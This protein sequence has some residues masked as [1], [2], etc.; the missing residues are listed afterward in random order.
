MFAWL[1]LHVIIGAFYRPIRQGR[2]VAYLTLVSFIFLV[3]ALVEMFV[4]TK[5]GGAAEKNAG[6]VESKQELQIEN[7]KLQI[8][9]LGVPDGDRSSIFN[10]QFAICNLQF[11]RSAL[12]G[13]RPLMNV[14]VVGCSHHGTSIVIRERLAFGRQQAEEAL[15][16]WRLSFRDVEGVLLSTCNRVEIYAAS[17]SAPIPG[18]E[19]IG[20]FLGPLSSARSAARSCRTCSSTPMKRPCG[21]CSAWPPAWTAWCSANLRSWPR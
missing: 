9:N 13:R 19:E 15:Q 21:T 2:K 14:Q 16:Q 3:F 17:E 6:N 8:A 7:C 11:P 20:Q 12:A 4:S 10:F 1:L 18:V 5:H